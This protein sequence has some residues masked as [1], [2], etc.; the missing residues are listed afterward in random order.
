MRLVLT[1]GCLCMLLIG[2]GMSSNAPTALEVPVSAAVVPAA[3]P[4]P[5]QLADCSNCQRPIQR[6]AKARPAPEPQAADEEVSARR[7][8]R[9]VAAR[10]LRPVGRVVGFLRRR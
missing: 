5:D 10:V 6:V 3:I 4:A 8:V 1:I 2:M 9:R 7:P